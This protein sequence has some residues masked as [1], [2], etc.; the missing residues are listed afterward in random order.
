MNIDKL[1]FHH[2]SHYV[3]L[4]CEKEGQRYITSYYKKM[5]AVLMQ[6]YRTEK[7]DMPEYFRDELNQSMMVI[8]STIA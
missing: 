1:K 6:I 7:V 4:G 2:F 8:S 5:H 3:I